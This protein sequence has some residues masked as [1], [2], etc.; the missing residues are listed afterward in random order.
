[1]I[2]SQTES[3]EH[4]VEPFKA[5]LGRFLYSGIDE[6]PLTLLNSISN[7]FLRDLRSA[8]ERKLDRLVFLGTHAIIQTVG[9]H[10]FNRRGKDA[11]GFY[12]AHFVDGTESHLK[13]SE[14][15]DLIH[16]LRNVLAHQWLSYRSYSYAIDYRISEGW[17]HGPDGIHINPAVYLDQ[18]LKGFDADDKI[19]SYR[20]LLTERERLL[21]K[22]R[23]ITSWLGL[24][25]KHP[26]SQEVKRLAT[27]TDGDALAGAERR[28]REMIE[29]KYGLRS[30]QE[31]G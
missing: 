29:K 11:T 12:L 26:I 30:P 16:E 4:P 7:S 31:I 18:F 22:Y 28:I 3:E 15:A 6:I 19:W 20:D 17:A 24:K 10:I 13:F 21:V 27:L 14:I 2:V 1:L 25:G 8:G 5:R 9:K 23:Y